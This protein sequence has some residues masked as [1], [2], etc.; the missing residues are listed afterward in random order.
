MSKIPVQKIMFDKKSFDKVVDV[1]FRQLG[2]I[3]NFIPTFT[4]DDFF[5]LY[6]Q[7]FYQIPKTGDINS[8]QYILQR[9]AEYLGIELNQDNVQALLDE[10]TILRQE[11]INIQSSISGSK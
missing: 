9:E 2:Q 8:H 1:N 4:L 5:S 10:I 7:V 11:L 6:D 3:T